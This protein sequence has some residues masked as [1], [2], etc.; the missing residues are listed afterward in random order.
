MPRNTNDSDSGEV[1]L[2]R[3][4]GWEAFKMNIICYKKTTVSYNIY[5]KEKYSKR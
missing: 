3:Q 4:T 5:I 1:G 2:G